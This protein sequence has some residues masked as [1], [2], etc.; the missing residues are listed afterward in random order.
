MR[1][2]AAFLLAALATLGG[3]LFLKN[4]RIEG[5]DGI[6]LSPDPA[7]HQASLPEPGLSVTRSGDVIRIGT[8]NIQVFGRAKMEKP[9]VM[10]ILARIARRFDVLAIQEIRSRDQNILPR[11][12]DLINAT[13]GHYDYVIGPPVGRTNSTEQ[14]A[15]IFDRGSIE[16]DR[17]QLYTVYDPDDLLHRE[18]L[19]GWFRV[20]GP[21]PSQAFTFTLINVHTDPDEVDRE[22]NV[23]DDVYRAVRDDGRQEDDIILLGDLNVDDRKLGDLSRISG[24]TWIVAGVPTNTRGTKQYDN[25]LFHQP[26]TREFTGRGGVFDFMREYNLTMEAALE[27]SDHLPV[28]AEF[29]IYEGGRVGPIATRP[30]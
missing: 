4:Y 27:V 9:H 16:V 13:G 19:V 28:W 21:E 17:N 25:I 14:Y 6:R 23:L 2:P 30:Q 11:F 7:A 1:K 12:V 29:S 26:S 22:I 18:P 10:D 8:F 3:W 24:M 20:R 15:Y 5:L